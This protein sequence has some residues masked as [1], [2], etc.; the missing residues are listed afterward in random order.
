MWKWRQIVRGILPF[1][2]FI[3]TFHRRE[4]ITRADRKSQVRRCLVFQYSWF[5]VLVD[6]WFSWRKTQTLPYLRLPIS[7]ED[8]RVFTKFELFSRSPASSRWSRW[9]WRGRRTTATTSSAASG[10]PRRTLTQ[11][12]ILERDSYTKCSSISTHH[13]SWR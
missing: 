6:L 10:P 7:S 4:R 5:L 13:S 1:N 9:T 2:Y 3:L 12:R 11:T 8:N